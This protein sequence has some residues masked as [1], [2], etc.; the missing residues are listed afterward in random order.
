MYLVRRFG[1]SIGVSGSFFKVLNCLG[2]FEFLVVRIGKCNLLSEWI[3]SYFF[4]RSRR[5]VI[6]LVVVIVRVGVWW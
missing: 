2:L 1:K 3:K 5:S 6:F 4:E